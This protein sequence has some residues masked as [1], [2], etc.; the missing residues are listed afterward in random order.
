MDTAVNNQR[1][2]IWLVGCQA[3]WALVVRR[4]LPVLDVNHSVWSPEVLKGVRNSRQFT[5]E[6]H[7]RF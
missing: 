3:E 1:L 7:P 6:L 5:G 4:L 2:F